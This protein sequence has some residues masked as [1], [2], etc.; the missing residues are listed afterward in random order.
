M[1]SFREKLFFVKEKERICNCL[2]YSDDNIAVI[3]SFL[4][5]KNLISLEV[6]DSCLSLDRKEMIKIIYKSF[7]DE[8]IKY[9]QEALS[10]I[11]TN[12]IYSII[13]DSRNNSKYF[14]E[15]ICDMKTLRDKKNLFFHQVNN[16]FIYSLYDLFIKCV[17]GTDNERY[18]TIDELDNLYKD[19]ISENKE[20]ILLNFVIQHRS[21]EN[22]FFYEILKQNFKGMSYV[23]KDLV[24]SLF[25][26][27]KK[28]IIL[29]MDVDENLQIYRNLSLNFKDLKEVALFVT[30]NKGHIIHLF[31][32]TFYLLQPD[33]YCFLYTVKNLIWSF[34]N[35]IYKCTRH[36][37]RFF[38][39]CIIV[40]I[41][42]IIFT[43]FSTNPPRTPYMG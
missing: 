39:L 29:F 25:K 41:F 27:E 32:K 31:D 40:G 4:L 18:E 11:E 9:F 19:I 13:K 10:V 34:F 22:D 15:F 30:W 12:R 20:K 33:F 43:N 42:I 35:F 26:Y 28:N 38:S 7:Y 16:L 24:E 3:I 17:K 1:S 8:G 23:T 2:S 14:D 36:F 5:Q 6:V 37:Y 21:E